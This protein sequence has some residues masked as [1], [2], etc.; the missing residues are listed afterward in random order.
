MK[1]AVNSRKKAIILGVL[2]GLF[3][4]WWYLT[5]FP[6]LGIVMGLLGGFFTFF[7]LN[8]RRMERLRVA[9]FLGLAILVFITLAA[10]ILY[11]GYH[12]FLQ[13]V[14]LWDVSYYTAGA[15]AV[16]TSPFPLPTQIPTIMLGQAKFLVNESTWLTTFDSSWSVFFL[17]MIPYLVT[18]LV[19]ERVF[20]GWICPMGGL[21]EGMSSMMK[22]RVWFFRFLDKK[23]AAPGG[24]SLTGLSGLKGWVEWVRYAILAG[25]F[26]WSLLAPFAIVNII[27][28]AL[29]MKSF[30][31]FWTV[32][33]FLVVFAVVLPFMTKRR[34]WCFVVC[35]IGATLSLFH[36]ISLFRI[37]IDKTKCNECM[38]CVQE[39]RVFAMTP[40]GVQ[41]GEPASGNCI[42][43]GRCIEACP[44]EA[45]DIALLGR[46]NARGAFLTL[47]ITTALTW[48]L[49]FVVLLVSYSTRLS[50]FKGFAG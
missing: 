20:C 18:F 41:R 29:W 49:W 48:Y 31:V 15:D 32:V 19:F 50:N 30:P 1:P 2:V 43:C 7:V 11:I 21:P 4:F 27:S 12:S 45:I 9:W 28:P 16:G 8:T 42:R 25:I 17:L 6:W 13:W 33:A 39:C 35:P 26:I 47:V 34:W 24:F 44:E 37:K 5:P 36:R 46:R 40:Q 38:D 14:R 23:P 3:T 10:N 22:K